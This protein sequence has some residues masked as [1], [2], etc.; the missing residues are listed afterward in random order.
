MDVFSAEC[1]SLLDGWSSL[2]LSLCRSQQ[3][4]VA[5]PM[6]PHALNDCYYGGRKYP[7]R[8]YQARGMT[9]AAFH[10]ESASVMGRLPDLSIFIDNFTAALSHTV[11]TLR[12]RSLSSIRIN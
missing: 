7:R 12:L 3:Y 8:L 6:F 9:L 4:I 11:T 10:E 5:L 2:S 1:I